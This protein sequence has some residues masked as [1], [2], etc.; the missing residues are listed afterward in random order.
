[1]FKNVNIFLNLE[2]DVINLT[3][4]LLQKD[5][6]TM[7][8]VFVYIKNKRSIILVPMNIYEHSVIYHAVVTL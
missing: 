2:T 6:T 7:H 1:M 3:F 8:N 5:E 4:V